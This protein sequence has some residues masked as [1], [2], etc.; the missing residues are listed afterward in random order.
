[1]V[2]TPDQVLYGMA[3]LI[4]S[5]LCTISMYRATDLDDKDVRRSLTF[6]LFCSGIWSLS[7]FFQ[8]ILT[9][10][11]AMQ[12][13]YSIGVS[14]GLV[15]VPSWLYFCS[16]ITERDYHRI[17]WV[18]TATALLI[19]FIVIIK[20]TN[21]IHGMYFGLELKQEP[22][23]HLNVVSYTPH[24]IV[25]IISYVFVTFGFV[26]LTYR[27]WDTR[28][29]TD[30]ILIIV[31]TIVPGFISALHLFPS[32]G[33]LLDMSY[34]SIGVGLFSVLVVF[35]L[36]NSITDMKVSTFRSL[37]D[38]TPDPIVLISED[39]NIVDFNRLASE[40]ISEIEDDVIGKNLDEVMG[41]SL[42]RKSGSGVTYSSQ[43]REYAAELVNLSSESPGVDSAIVFEEK[44]QVKEL[45]E[46]IEKQENREDQMSKSL[47]DVDG[48]MDQIEE[49]VER[50]INEI[51]DE[52][53][54][55]S[56]QDIMDRVREMNDKIT[57]VRSGLDGGEIQGD[58]ERE[59]DLESLVY[60]GL[61]T[62]NTGSIDVEVGING[63]IE[64]QRSQFLS[65]V[66]EVARKAIEQDNNSITFT[67]T[68]GVVTITSGEE[69]Y[70]DNSDP[71]DA[72][73]VLPITNRVIQ[74]SSWEIIDIQE[75]ENGFRVRF[76]PNPDE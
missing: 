5:I 67:Y 34:E 36:K 59:H 22:F 24:I 1:M 35:V 39:Y 23:T 55:S 15:T 49:E 13:I 31:L 57:A 4:T 3:F 66:R 12:V 7:E 33:I 47:A 42:N 58:G 32:Q 19:S 52:N 10:K 41:N 60:S 28:Y 63:N 56:F 53:V 50:R 26:L 73:E 20:L 76:D 30:I 9:D 72:S 8:V 11:F 62:V 65:I 64:V 68:K 37:L 29:I 44:T 16:S 18:R 43:G 75:Y 45:E 48:V 70:G 21:I 17:G 54:D 6:L 71:A 74:L 2:D 27:F 69:Q 40:E 14:F 51:D 46:Y 38:T 61:T 25:N